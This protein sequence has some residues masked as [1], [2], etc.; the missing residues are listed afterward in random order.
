MVECDA[1]VQADLQLKGRSR[2]LVSSDPGQRYRHGDCGLVGRGKLPFK[3][4]I[5]RI[6]ASGRYALTKAAFIGFFCAKAEILHRS[7]AV[8]GLPSIE[9]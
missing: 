6:P 7:M 5:S 1:F 4:W 9:V 2:R 3:S 8:S